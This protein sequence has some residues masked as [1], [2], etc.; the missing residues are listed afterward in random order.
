[1]KNIIFGLVSLFILSCQV[2]QVQKLNDGILI[3]LKKPAK[4][5]ARVIRLQVITD[6][7]IHVSA[8]PV[9][10][11]P[12]F[13][14]LM[15]VDSIQKPVKWDIQE[16][17]EKVVLQTLSL[18][19]SVKLSSGEIA[20]SDLNG[21]SI[22]TEQKGGGKYFSSVKISNKPFYHIRQV[23]E[24]PSNEAIYGLGQQQLGLVNY[25]NQDVDLFQ[26]NTK[27]SIPFIVSNK[28]YGILWDNYS[29]SKFGDIREYE[30]LSLLKLYSQDGQKGGLT[31]I[32]SS[33]VDSN[34]IFLKRTETAIAYEFL[35][36]TKD[37]PAEF[38]IAQGKV[39]WT[40]YLES[41]SSGIH[42]FKLYSSGYIKIWLNGEVVVPERWRQPWNAGTTIFNVEMEKGKKYPVKIEWIPD[43]G[44]AYCSLKCLTPQASGEQEKLSFY[45]EVAKQIDYYFIKG[46]NIDDVISGY[47]QIT[48]KAAMMPKWAMGFW[49]SRERYTCQDTIISIASKFRKRN[50]PIDNLVLDW[51]YWEEKKWGD[52]EF[53]STRFPE[54]G[55]MVEDLHNQYH[56][57]F[58]ISVW[59]KFYVGT[60]NYKVMMDK[61]WL[62]K[63][64]IE[65]KHKDWVG[66]GYFSTFYDAFNP[67]ARQY[68]WD[69][70]NEKL[71]SKG[72]DAWWMDASEP[73]MHSNLSLQERKELMDPTAL[74]PGAE[75]F[76]AYPFVNAKGIY[77]GQRSTKPNQRVFILTRS[78]YAGQQRFAAATWSGDIASRWEDMKRQVAAGIGF[79][80]SGIP[81]WTMDIGGFSIENRYRN[82]QGAVL[83]EWREMNTRWYQ[84]GSFC[85]IFRAHGQSPFREVFNIAPENH[86]AYQSIVFYDKL[87]YR[88][89]PY[90]YSLGGMVYL[91]NY[92]I[93][94]GLIM[95]FEA[96][97]A[98]ENINDQY[99]FGPA[100]LICPVVE[101]KATNRKV[102]LP[103]TTGWY[104]LYT[105]KYLAGGQQILADAPYSRIP[106]FVK[107]GSIIPI[108][109]EIQYSNEKPA[110][111][112][113]LFIYTGKNAS[114]TLYEDENVNYNYEKGIYSTI[115]FSYNDK[116]R[117]LTIGDR[118]GSY[119]GMPETR[120]FNIILITKN[121]PAGLDFN[122]K[123][124]KTIKYDGKSQHIQFE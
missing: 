119:P 113:I 117:T 43:G 20:F 79:C 61:G 85:P 114:F 6:K 45:S 30:P 19:V 35:N 39:T 115:T 51:F 77:E 13:K 46:E 56:I 14:S 93:M 106:V 91:N 58:M 108:G 29:E 74:G 72:I 10:S 96:D 104:N 7:I 78:A 65:L 3:H 87:R 66:P 36:S 83:D 97:T 73:D 123:P 52:H 71:F 9:Q 42:K 18:R 57:H 32:Y 27:V 44:Q 76:N 4:S 75:F 116:I 49:Q 8:I 21:K 54:P 92:T 111:P 16:D 103:A 26:Y 86:P 41:D 59:P 105:G 60:N 124:A 37:I 28:N 5:A 88:L 94:R 33:R 24:S 99:M 48:G 80:I 70:I 109:P 102:Y 34:K 69:Q 40:G 15:V 17:S 1:M 2:H 53:D 23:F 82:L 100:L 84:F 121:K 31:A 122:L 63:K 50:I 68:F 22:L 38:P 89:M 118:A 47:R 90:I 12:E 11:F 120:T 107:E 64:N 112:V 101:Y 55:K 62:Y 98:V 110:D 81:Y 67:R 95:D 25:K